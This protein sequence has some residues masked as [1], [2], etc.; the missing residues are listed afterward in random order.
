M[1][2]G[3]QVRHSRGCQH[4]TGRCTCKPSFEA[5]VWSERDGRKISRRFRNVSEAKGWR[6]DALA[7]LRAGSLRASNGTTVRHAADA[8]L[9]GAREGLIRTRSGDAYK[10]SALRGYD[11][12]L[13]DYILPTLG[14]AKLSDVR[15]IDVQD[16]ADKLATRGLNPSTIRNALMPLR[17]LYRR[18]VARG[19]VAVNPT[20]GVQLPAVRGRRERI[21]SPTEAATLIAALPEDDRAM[22]TTAF[23]AGLR[24]GERRA[25]RWEDIDLTA[26]VIRVT[27]SWDQKAGLV[28]PK[29]R[30]GRRAVPIPTLLRSFLVAH[31]IRCAWAEGFAFGRSQSRP[32][33]PSSVWLRAST[34]W[35]KA[36]L[37]PIGLHEAR[38]TYASLMIAAGVNA[39]ALSTYMGHSSVTITYDRYGHLMPG[40]EDEEAALLDAYLEKAAPQSRPSDHTATAVPSGRGRWRRGEQRPGTPVPKPL[41]PRRFWLDGAEGEGFEPS[42]DPEARN[43]FRDRRIRPLCHP[44]ERTA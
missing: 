40:N 11:Q 20:M 17:A 22:W 9:D 33:N 36:K 38:H 3:V 5:W 2:T 29:S 10:P 18:A 24:L 16:L 37:A 26:G 41:L 23:Y 21:A 4:R 30:A 15:R 12:A 35:R 31:K 13:R 1:A 43:G 34:A 19:E 42:S 25:L 8:W 32:F 44:S 27:A 39:K 6:A 7:A 14:G 28:E